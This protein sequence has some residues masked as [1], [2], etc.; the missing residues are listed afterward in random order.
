MEGQRELLEVIDEESDRLNRFIEALSHAGQPDASQPPHPPAG[1][2]DG[3]LRAG[4]ARAETITRYHRILVAI[5]TGLPPSC[6]ERPSTL[7]A[8]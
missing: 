3:I 8:M 6:V 1:A 2:L 5:D 4:P 7:E